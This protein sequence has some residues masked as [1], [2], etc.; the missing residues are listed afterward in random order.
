MSSGGPSE[1]ELG[2]RSLLR[3]AGA[4]AATASIAGCTGENE[5]EPT[6]SESE[7]A[8]D[9]GTDTER[10]TPEG[11]PSEGGELTV[12]FEAELTGLD[13][14]RTDSVV[15][16]VVNYNICETLITFDE[17]APSDR[18]T[19]DWSISDDGT[20]YTFTLK[21]GV[22]F[23]PPV[24]R[25]MVAEDVVYSFERMNQEAAMA[26]DL[27][28]VESV[29]ATGDY[30]VTFTLSSAFAP[31]INF[32]ARV[33]WVVIP[34][35]SVENQ[36]GELGDVQEPVGTGPF[37]FDEQQ[38]GNF[39][40]LTA[41]DGY[42]A[43]DVPYLD[44]VRVQPIP[45]PDSRVAAVRAGDVDMARQIPGQD[46]ETLEGAE[47]VSV[48]Q[49][50][51]TTWAQVHINCETEPWD[52][53]AVRR[54]VAHVINRADIVEAGVSGY[55][56]AAWQPYPEESIWNYDLGD[57]ARQRDVEGAQQILE[58][59]GNP[60][61][62]VTL[63]IKANTSYPVMETTA[64]LLVAEL[65][66]AG[67]D[68][69]TE[70]LE[71][72]TQLSDFLEG[73]YGAMAFSVPFKIDPDR[74]YF[75][76]IHPDSPQYNGYT[77]DQPD[78]ERMYELLEQGRTETDQETRIETYT[79]LQRLV[80]KNLPWI[81]VAQTDDLIGLRSDVGGYQSWLLPYTRWW[82]MYKE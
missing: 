74:H 65:N 19:S 82:T 11:G 53:P 9:T 56:R 72:G 44:S 55:G 20:E 68:A 67:I 75:S 15:S 66:A 34:E 59:A 4:A 57:S 16:W 36:G 46:A 69:E 21:E 45:D 58:D 81:S 38:P 60:L 39:L 35:E 8:T 31:L 71:W 61:E 18:L 80:N 41:F 54:A 32:L 23:H 70:I 27:S 52:Q 79:E 30:E 76:F 29:E 42:R 47:G 14:H 51:G 63:S 48:L 13:P 1:T 6:G 24:D 12:G 2:R 73:N 33:P 49:Q 5:S 7:T 28:P 78:A 26:G 37:M 22:M 62:D 10:S 77:E 40:R 43:D 50:R 17:G 25:E 3:Y 64:N